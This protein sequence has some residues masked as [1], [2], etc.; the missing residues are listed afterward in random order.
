MLPVCSGMFYSPEVN[1]VCYVR[2]HTRHH[3]SCSCECM[4]S[5]AERTFDKNDSWSGKYE[6]TRNCVFMVCATKR[7]HDN[8]TGLFAPRAT[9]SEQIVTLQQMSVGSHK[10]RRVLT[11]DIFADHL[12]IRAIHLHWH[13]SFLKNPV[14]IILAARR[15]E[16]KQKR[17]ART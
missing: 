14:N 16:K 4:G 8:L 11:T 9:K 1:W 6:L 7:S 17:A 2:R 5:M 15:C 12:E 13:L 10:T 3:L